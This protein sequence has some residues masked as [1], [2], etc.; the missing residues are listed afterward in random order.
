[1]KSLIQLMLL[2]A[3]I[4]TICPR[5][6]ADTDSQPQTVDTLRQQGYTVKSITPIFGQ[7]L[8]TAF[9]PGFVPAYENTNGGHYIRE[10]V[11]KGEN[12]N[13]WT[14]MLT[15]TGH[16]GFSANPSLTPRKFAEIKANGFNNACPGTFSAQGL[17]E[18][19][20][21]AYDSFVVILS[22]GISPSSAGQTSESALIVVIK[23][24]TDYY[25]VQW[26]ERAE[27]SSTPIKI[28]PTK[29]IE[30]FKQ[31]NPIKL[32]PIVPG[33]AAPYPSCVGQSGAP[34]T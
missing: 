26:A 27:K 11:L 21:G 23:G 20:I 22:C 25:T 24:D 31:L 19:K 1:M 33:E 13:K 2:T 3:V 15:F 5:A 4:S 29:W 14:Q 32:C 8:V 17:G 28:E 7:L 16:K 12:V 6:K 10:S 9:P 34:Q 18:G 30:R